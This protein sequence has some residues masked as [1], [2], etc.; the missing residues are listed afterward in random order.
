MSYLSFLIANRRFLG[1]GFLLALSSSFGQTYYISVYGGEIREVFDLS[2][3]GF[4]TVYSI[5]TLASGLLLM[6]LGT[7]IDRVDLRIYG[8]SL[9]LGLATAC[10]LMA[11]TPGVV[12]L[13]FTIFMLRMFGQGLLSHAATTSMARYFGSGERG[14]AV[15]IAALGFPVAQGIF[16]AMAVILMAG[17]GWRGAWWASAAILVAIVP[18][19]LWLLRGHSKRHDA[20][21]EKTKDDTGAKSGA[22]KRRQWTRAEVIRDP[23]FALTMLAVMGPSFIVTGTM[24]H[25]VHLVE[26]KGWTLG[27]FAAS[28]IGYSATQV[29][30]A[31]IAGSLVDRF[32]AV[33]LMPFYL[34]PLAC[35]MLVLS[36][37]DQLWAAPAFMF[38]VGITGGFTSNL[39]NTVWA[40]LY[41]VLNL[42]SIRALVA[43]FSVIA[44]ALSPVTFGVLFDRGV[45]FEAVA[46]G[47]IFYTLFGAALL[48]L[49]YRRGGMVRG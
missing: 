22:P 13:A 1:F 42:G 35:G 26:A 10:V 46:V 45:S 33:R 40:E 23:R 47:S 37:Y 31:L 29:G 34:L 44:S 3:G 15:S 19:A 38:L 32:G 12:V 18:I 30:T 43:S 2:H 21:L 14:R 36:L 7:V 9:L 20:M 17:L 24:F 4:G 5:G 27:W 49:V 8:P 6:W 28:F 25:Q 41:G 11:I 39:A 48:T 16:P